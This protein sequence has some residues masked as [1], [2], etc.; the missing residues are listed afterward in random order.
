HGCRHRRPRPTGTVPRQLRALHRPVGCGD[1]RR[2]RRLG[3]RH[4]G[5]RRGCAGQPEF[6]C[7][8]SGALCRRCV[9]R[10]VPAPDAG[11]PGRDWLPYVAG[12]LTLLI[13]VLFILWPILQLL[14][15][16]FLP[17]RTPFSL[18]ALT[19]DNFSRFF[20]AATYRSAT[21]NSIV[22]SVLS[23]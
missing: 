3:A 23:T 19:L 4:R 18:D 1:P 21:I 10:S 11:R 13:L 9:V 15:A 8:G 22:V 5:A 17:V 14:V 16:A 2:D 7:V 12:G 20:V 6:R